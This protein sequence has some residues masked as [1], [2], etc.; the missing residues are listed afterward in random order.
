MMAIKPGETESASTRVNPGMETI[1]NRQRV[2]S[3]NNRYLI[4]NV[5]NQRLT[6][7]TEQRHD[8]QKQNQNIDRVGEYQGF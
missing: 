3:V 4:S 7:Y 1:P 2:R 5:R 8:Q 6:H